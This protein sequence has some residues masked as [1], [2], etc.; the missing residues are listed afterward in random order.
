MKNKLL[1]S[2]ALTACLSAYAQTTPIP[3]SNFEAELIAQGIDTNG[4]NGNI[5]TADAEGHT[6]NL[7]ISGKDI[8]DL[9]GIAA[10]I[11]VT[12]LNMQNNS[13]VGALDLSS[14]TKLIRITAN[15]NALTSI[16]FNETDPKLKFLTA[17]NNY[18]TSANFTTQTVLE[19]VTLGG[20]PLTEIDLSNAPNLTKVNLNNLRNLDTSATKTLLTLNLANGTNATNLSTTVSVDIR[21][22]SSLTCVQVD[23]V[24][25]STTT[26]TQVPLSFVGYSLDC[27]TLITNN[28]E[29]ANVLVLENPIQNETIKISLNAKALYALFNTNGKVVSNGSLNIGANQINASNLVSGIYLLKVKTEFGTSSNKIIKK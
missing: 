11:N 29:L 13:V 20:N 2:T 19:E 16:T 4:A 6:T 8:S 17:I 15:N 1:L 23:N 9:T 22:N 3:D 5:L 24:A 25:H 7:N 12:N 18:I 21:N 27:Y 28:Y 10:F 26:W 14:L